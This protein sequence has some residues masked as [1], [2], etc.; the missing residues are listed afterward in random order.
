M[1]TNH[2]L[3]VAIVCGLSGMS[4]VGCVTDKPASKDTHIAHAGYSREQAKKDTGVVIAKPVNTA[5]KDKF[6]LYCGKSMSSQSCFSHA[7]SRLQTLGYLVLANGEIHGQNGKTTRYYDFRFDVPNSLQTTANQ[8]K[9]DWSNPFI[10]SAVVQFERNNGFL[11]PTGVSYGNVHKNVLKKLFSAGAKKAPRSWEWVLVDKYIG[12]KHAETLYVWKHSPDKSGYIFS[13]KVN[14][15][16][17]GSTPNGTWPIYQRLPV[18]TMQG[19]FPIPITWGTYH[20]LRGQQV[21]QWLGSQLL[22]SARGVVNGNP[23]RWLPYKDPG[24]LWVNY[25]DN[26]RGIHYYPRA[27]YGFPQSA[28]CV[29]EPLPSAKHVYKLLHYGV[30]VTVKN[31]R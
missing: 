29:E 20:S 13:T 23:V 19:V 28:G 16:V 1:D 17:M 3:I 8:Y 18:T 2:R 24:I 21:P 4:L 27:S 14:T 22:Q 5:R 10:R 9:W 12:S 7:V 15:G 26:G 25:F 6:T 11:H 31:N 30:P